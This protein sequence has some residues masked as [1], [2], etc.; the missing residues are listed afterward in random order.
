MMQVS[1]AKNEDRWECKKIERKKKVSTLVSAR[2][3]LGDRGVSSSVL[4]SIEMK[5]FHE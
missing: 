1:K 3:N 5:G 2:G 4:V